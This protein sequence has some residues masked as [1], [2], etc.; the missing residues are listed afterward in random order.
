VQV[1]PTVT[2]DGKSVPVAEVET[3][4]LNIVLPADNIFGLP[5]ENARA[6]RRARLGDTPEPADAGTHTIVIH[7]GTS[8]ITTTILVK[9]GDWCAAELARLDGQ[10]HVRWRSKTCRGGHQ[11]HTAP[12]VNKA[13]QL[14]PESTAPEPISRRT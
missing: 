2:V 11:H 4:L 1:A 6:V 5:A 10:P 12:P 8:P 9:P 7:S 3:Q 13:S 14:P